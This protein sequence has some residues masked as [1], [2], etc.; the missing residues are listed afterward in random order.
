MDRG[1]WEQV[2]CTRFITLAS[3]ILELFPFVKFLIEPGQVTHVFRGTPNSSYFL[4]T[5]RW[6][7]PYTLGKQH[8]Q[9][10]QIRIQ[11]VKLWYEHLGVLS[12]SKL[13][14]TR[15]TFSPILSVI[16]AL[17][18]VKT[19]AQHDR[20][21]LANSLGSVEYGVEPLSVNEHKCH[22]FIDCVRFFE[23]WN[24]RYM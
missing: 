10:L 9:I 18:K 22:I 20:N 17:W 1:W 19:P 21:A 3:I 5:Q 14:D 13:S 15:T 24:V 8:W 23:Q 6:C 2:S 16:K 4:T 7:K 12:G 11:T